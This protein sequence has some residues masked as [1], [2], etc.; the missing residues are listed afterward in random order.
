[1]RQIF[2]KIYQSLNETL[3]D[4]KFL[5]YIILYIR[6]STRKRFVHADNIRF[7]GNKFDV[8]D[9]PSFLGQCRELFVDEIYRFNS[10]TDNPVI[11]DCGANIGASCIYFKRLYPM[12]AIKAFEPDV[13]IA[14]YLKKNILQNGLHGVEVIESAVWIHNEGIEFS[15]EG[16]DGG[17]IQGSKD[18]Q[19]VTTIRLKDYLEREKSIDMLKIDIEGAEYDVL[20]DCQDSLG[21]VKNI[22][23]EYHSWNNSRQNLSKLLMILEKNSFRYFINGLRNRKHPFVNKGLDQNMDLQLNIFGVRRR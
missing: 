1:M 3:L 9:I 21:K 8:P 2:Y 22:F 17:S 19:K 18:L 10:D 15:S 11:F 4:I 20:E 13:G 12:A 5:R 7:L 23:V 14:N 16:A 6:W